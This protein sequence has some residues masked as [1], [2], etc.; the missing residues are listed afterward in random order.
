MSALLE[1]YPAYPF[2][3]D[4]GA[5]DR[6]YDEDGGAWWDYYGGHCVTATGHSHPRVV[7]A[8]AEQASRLIFYSAAARLRVREQAAA[9]LI[10]FVAGCGL[11][12]VFFCNSGAEANEN[13]LKLAL[14]LTGRRRL[15]AFA[16]GWHGRTLLALS[17]TDD[18][19]I[20]QPYRELLAPCDSLPF[21]DLQALESF[22]FS[23][24]AAVIVEPIQSMSGIR[25]ATP[26]WFQALRAR[27]RAAGCLLI[28]DEIQTG[29]GRLGTP[30]AAHHYGIEPDIVCLAKG[31]ASGVP[32]GATLVSAAVA[33]AV[34]KGDLGST[35]GGGPLAC[36]ALRATLAVIGDEQ[37]MARAAAL[38]A[39]FKRSLPGA[40]VAEVRG[41]G[42]LLGLKTHG[43]AAAVKDALYGR[44]ILAGG[45]GDPQ[46]LRLMPPLTLSDAAVDALEA[47]LKE[48][49]A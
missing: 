29:V 25:C 32:I 42:L 23:Q 49:Q 30:L 36:A 26:Q 21:G 1:T 17:V 20:T 48:F 44:R 2:V 31:L 14:K 40:V 4:R 19:K 39:H 28:F 12:R 38:G 46:V 13:A 11:A 33:G 37:L 6:V 10:D 18:A 47:A 34:Q 9:A 8:I 5:G 43:P 3:L 41:E 45:S 15:A 7:A 22:D 35:F 27:T 24:T 16:G